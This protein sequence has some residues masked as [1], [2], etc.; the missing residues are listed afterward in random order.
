M[1]KNL[2]NITNF[3]CSHRHT[4]T[5]MEFLNGPLSLFYACPKYYEQN[6][7][8]GELMCSMRL[9]LVDAE[10]ILDKFS[11]IVLKDLEDDIIRDY[12]NMEFEY[13][14][15]HVKVLHYDEHHLDL[16]ILNK[17]ALR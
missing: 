14:A 5:K 2:W 6:R 1:L 10:G 16:D 3:Y 8:P 17:K 15:I 12:T 9:N 7:E 13:K 4:P 11:S